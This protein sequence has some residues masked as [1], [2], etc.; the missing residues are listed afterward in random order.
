MFFLKRR[1][2]GF[3]LIELLVVIAIIGILAAFLTPAVQK[4][5]EKARRTGCASNLRQIGVALHLYAADW[6]EKFPELAGVGVAFQYQALGVLYSTY[7]DT[8]Q[9]FDCPSDDKATDAISDGI[10]LSNSSYA[11]DMGLNESNRSTMPIGSDNGIAAG[12]VVADDDNHGQDGVNV[13][14]VGGHVK[15]TPGSSTGVLYTTDVTD[16]SQ[17]AGQN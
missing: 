17:L 14:F 12:G 16:W 11:Y 3:T 9:I 10:T 1:A 5:R 6:E 13:L 7:L 2:W 15:W 8:A 4:A